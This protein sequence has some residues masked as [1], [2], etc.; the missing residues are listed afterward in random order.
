MHGVFLHVMGDTLGSAVVIVSTLIIWLTDFS[1]KYYVDPIASLIITIIILFTS[2]PLVKKT[3]TILLQSA[4][5]NI[6][7]NIIREKLLQV[8]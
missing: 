5:S 7:L 4:P 3:C 6:P 1:W 8:Q 2:I